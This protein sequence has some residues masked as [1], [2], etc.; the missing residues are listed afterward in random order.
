[1]RVVKSVC[2][3]CGADNCGLDVYLE[4]DQIVD[5]KGMREFPVNQGR[6]CPQARASMEMSSDPSRL[7]FPLRRVG[8]DWLRI[9][10]DQALDTIAEKLT[11][12][13]TQHGA[14]TLAVY[15]GRALLQFIRDGWAQRFMN[16]YG[17]PNLVR[18]EH[19]CAIPNALGEWLT[20]G[21][22][23]MYYG[24]DA[25]RMNCILLWGSN[26]VTSHSPMVWPSIVRAQNRGAKLIV[27]DPR[28]TKPAL[29]ADYHA[30]LRPG[31]DLALALG[32]INVIIQEQ[33]YDADFCDRWTS[34]LEQLTARVADYTPAKVA[35]ITGVPAELITQIARSYATS[36]P[37]YLD[38]GNALEHHSNSGQTIRAVMM[39][40]HADRQ[41]GRAGWA[42]FPPGSSAP[43]QCQAGGKTAGRH[44]DPDRPSTPPARG[45][46]RLCPR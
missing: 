17:T 24:F 18:N 41:P 31:T 5:I 33:L 8:R 10:W 32:L 4:G 25:E 6:L 9:T 15:Q 37:A 38:A 19:M 43:V 13:K 29:R 30:V 36:K 28:T 22:P 7:K 20:Y 14:H 21:S 23:S 45:Y 1:M 44:P 39:L 42:P 16:L 12:V 46:D 35:G 34:G 2:G 11:T 3:M 26:P 40:P 27:V